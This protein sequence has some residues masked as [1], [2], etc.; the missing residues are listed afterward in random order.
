MFWV[1]AIHVLRTKCSCSL[2]LED[3]LSIINWY[4]YLGIICARTSRMNKVHTIKTQPKCLASHQ[5]LI[6]L[7]ILNSSSHL[8]SHLLPLYLEVFS[9]YIHPH[10]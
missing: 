5:V 6:P 1:W 7:Y 3:Y 4:C 2:D 10:R 8:S 9:R